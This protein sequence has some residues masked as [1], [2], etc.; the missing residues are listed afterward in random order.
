MV[1]TRPLQGVGMTR[2]LAIRDEVV[3][4]EMLLLDQHLAGAGR[5]VSISAVSWNPL[6][7]Q[8]QQTGYLHH[9]CQWRKRDLHEYREHVTRLETHSLRFSFPLGN[10]PIIDGLFGTSEE[11]IPTHG[12]Q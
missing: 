4:V 7:R 3:C 11:P 6:L 10:T 9:Q 8:I 12:Q 5:N 1:V 2:L